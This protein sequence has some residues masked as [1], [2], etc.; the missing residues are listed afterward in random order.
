MKK[1]PVFGDIPFFGNAFRR[2][3]ESDARTELMIFITP[4]VVET[5]A[6][7]AAAVEAQ[8]R[9]A[10]KAGLGRTDVEFDSP[11]RPGFIRDF[12]LK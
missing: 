4:T 10:E 3:T 9:V 8:K 6:E 1:V 7:M 12:I 11:V 5:E 2:R